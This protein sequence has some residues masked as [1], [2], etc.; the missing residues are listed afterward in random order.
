MN[1]VFRLFLCLVCLALPLANGYGSEGE[2]TI[3]TNSAEQERKAGERM[4]LTIN[5]VEYAFRWCPPGTFMMGSWAGD[6]KISGDGIRHQVTLTRGFWMLETEVTQKMWESVM[7]TNPS[8]FKGGKLPVERVSWDDCQ[9]YIEK[10]NALGSA[11]KGYRFSLPTEARWEYAC[12]ASTTTAYHFGNTLTKDQ[13]NFGRNVGQTSDVDSYP[14]NVWGLYDMHGNVSELCS[15]WYGNYPGDSMTDPTGAASGSY[16][17][18]RGGSWLHDAVGCRSAYRHN[19][20]PSHRS[21]VIGVR[22]SLVCDEAK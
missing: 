5:D 21:S 2:S 18:L 14:A 9:E 20:I 13:A 10:L 3:Q 4:V 22:L 19:T 6:P 11:P 16:R 17:A 8:E 12:R 15:D 7:E 1:T